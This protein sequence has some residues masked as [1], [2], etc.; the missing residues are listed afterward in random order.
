MAKCGSLAVQF[1]DSPGFGLV[2]DVVPA[3]DTALFKDYGDGIAEGDAP[4]CIA[5][6]RAARQSPG[7]GRR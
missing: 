1:D 6:Y 4:V 5:D 2:I 3:V 7:L